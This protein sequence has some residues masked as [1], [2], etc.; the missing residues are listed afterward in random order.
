MKNAGLK[1]NIQTTIHTHTKYS[2][3]MASSPTTSWHIDEEEV[4]T[5][6]YF[7]FL[8]SNITMDLDCSH[9]IKRY[10]S[11]GRKKAYEKSAQCVKKQRLTLLQRSVVSKL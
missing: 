11:L 2:T 7:I 4:E 5:V 1:L 6:A 9:K 3:F 10:L 8:G